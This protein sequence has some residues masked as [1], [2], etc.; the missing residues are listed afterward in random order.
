MSKLVTDFSNNKEDDNNLQETSDM[1]FEDFALKSN[2]LAFASRSKA[3][4][5]PQRRTS[6][7]SSAK[8]LYW[9][10]WTHIE[11]QDFSP[12]DYPVSKKLI[13]LLRHGNL[14]QEDDGVIEFW[15]LKV[16]FGAKLS[17]LNIGLVMCGRA[18]WQEAE[19][20]KKRF[21]YCTDPSGQEI[22]YLRALQG[23][24]RRNFIDPSLQDNV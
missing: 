18:R 2:V 19:A 11:P 17:T 1:Q 22:L 5:K 23:H 21:Q 12:I 7:S 8:T 3:K 9:R 20:N 13:N 10:F 6:A 4:A 15:R 16:I 24:S 14:P